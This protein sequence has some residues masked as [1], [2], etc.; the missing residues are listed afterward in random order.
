MKGYSS[1]TEVEAARSIGLRWRELKAFEKS[2]LAMTWS[3]DIPSAN[4]LPA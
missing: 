3:G 4:R 2:S 1:G